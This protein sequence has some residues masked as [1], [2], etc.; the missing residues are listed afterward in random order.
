MAGKKTDDGPIGFVAG[1][2][3]LANIFFSFKG[4]K[5]AYDLG[6]WPALIIAL[7]ICSIISLFVVFL[8]QTILL[9]IIT[10][11]AFLIAC[12]YNLK[13]VIAGMEQVLKLRE[14]VYIINNFIEATSWTS[15]LLA[16]LTLAMSIAFSFSIFEQE[17]EV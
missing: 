2:I 6:F 13:I 12:L 15:I 14:P 9:K 7:L 17:T 11:A 10:L 5:A 3:F 16:V 1:I 8:R 4:L